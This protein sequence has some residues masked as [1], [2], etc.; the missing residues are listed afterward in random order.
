MGRQQKGT[1]GGTPRRSRQSSEKASDLQLKELT[2]N[3]SKL[4][5]GSIDENTMS[6]VQEEQ[7]SVN[8]LDRSERE[9][10]Q[11]LYQI[12]ST[13]LA[14]LRRNKT[15]FA[16]V[17]LTAVA[18]HS[19]KMFLFQEDLDQQRFM[20]TLTN[21]MITS[22]VITSPEDVLQTALSQ[23]VFE[24]YHEA[25][26]LAQIILA[27]TKWCGTSNQFRSYHFDKAF[28]IRQDARKETVAAQE[29]QSNVSDELLSRDFLTIDT[30]RQKKP[31]VFVVKM[32]DEVN[33]LTTWRLLLSIAG[34]AAHEAEI[35]KQTLV[36]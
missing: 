15:I 13:N 19:I 26:K 29:D 31:K 16:K 18:R 24:N 28:K 33:A 12:A 10:M 21:T 7:G 8:W 11:K 14:M 20:D 1:G 25:R 3:L 22:P 35:Q 6:D 34:L 4:Q 30:K 17:I 36:E 5:L 27:L 32:E 2:N 9:E 23:P